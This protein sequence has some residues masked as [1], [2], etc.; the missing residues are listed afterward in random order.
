VRRSFVAS[1]LNS[2]ENHNFPSGALIPQP[3]HLYELFFSRNILYSN[4]RSIFFY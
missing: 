2:A 4:S 3:M 1:S